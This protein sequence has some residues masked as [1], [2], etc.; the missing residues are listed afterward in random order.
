M[1]RTIQAIAAYAGILSICVLFTLFL[2]GIAGSYLLG[3]ML[4]APVISLTVLLFAK[5]RFKASL[6]LGT[7]L[8][9]KGEKVTATLSV[10]Q[11]RLFFLSVF[12][13][14]IKNSYHL[15]AEDNVVFRIGGRKKDALRQRVYDCDFFGIGEVFIANVI[16]MDFLGL[17]SFKLNIDPCVCK[18]RILPL[19]KDMNA[20]NDLGKALSYT[21]AYN[22]S[23]ETNDKA[24]FTAGMPGYEH[25]EYAPGDP[26]KM[27]NWKL[28]AKRDTCL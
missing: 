14:E 2:D 17:I 27:V 5:L 11:S 15:S 25:R 19:Q 4:L 6:E 18:V 28:S 10:P 9:D 26:L 13:V 21:A 16:G 22:D 23:E 7:S 1:K 20:L 3:I 12:T 8:C 24:V